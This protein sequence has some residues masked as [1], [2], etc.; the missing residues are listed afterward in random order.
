MESLLKWK[1]APWRLHFCTSH[2]GK[3]L[4]NHAREAFK[5][6][7]ST[8]TREVFEK[9][10]ERHVSSVPSILEGHALHLLHDITFASRLESDF[11]DEA[12]NDNARNLSRLAIGAAMRAVNANKNKNK[13]PGRGEGSGQNKTLQELI[14]DIGKEAAEAGK[15]D[16]ALIYLYDQARVIRLVVELAL[17]MLPP[18]LTRRTQPLSLAVPT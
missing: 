17:R 10:Q 15:M 2:Q 5:T 12:S 14:G 8:T 6:V 1:N 4:Y 16:I 9:C 7:P 3:P 18:L 13:L 11:D